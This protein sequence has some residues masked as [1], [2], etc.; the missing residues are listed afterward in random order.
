M[1]VAAD[2]AVIEDEQAETRSTSLGDQRMG[3]G[4]QG[5]MLREVHRLFDSG[6]VAG[7]GEEELL[8]RFV[9]HRDEAAFA[10]LLA[11]HGPIVLGVC[12]R[13]LRDPRDVEDAFQ[14]TVLI[15]IRKAGSIKEPHLLGPWLHGVAYRVAHRARK[16][17]VR[18]GER[19]RTAAM[20]QEVEDPTPP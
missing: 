16:V 5:A 1:R 18:R 8:A 7:L 14:A 19:E 6:T 4:H 17:A 3:S 9:S 10:A 13:W 2:R 20:I 12:R 15:L 11:R